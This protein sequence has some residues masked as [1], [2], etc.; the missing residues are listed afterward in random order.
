VISNFDVSEMSVFY[1]FGVEAA[2]GSSV[3]LDGMEISLKDLKLAI[4]DQKKLKN[5]TDFDLS[6]TNSQ[7][8]QVYKDESEMIN[9]GSTVSVGRIPMPRGEKK[10]WRQ[11]RVAKA[12]IP[13]LGN[14]DGLIPGLGGGLGVEG[15]QPSI[16]EEERL[17]Q[18]VDNS[19]NEYNVSN[20]ERI[21]NQRAPKP[22]AGESFK[23]VEK[24]N[25][26][27][28]K[29]MFLQAESV[30]EKLDA[31]GLKFLTQVEIDGYGKDK[32]ESH[33]WLKQ[34]DKREERVKEN[35]AISTKVKRA[36]DIGFRDQRSKSPK[37]RKIIEEKSPDNSLK[38][39]SD[40]EHELKSKKK[41]LTDQRN[42]IVNRSQDR[43]DLERAS[44][45][46]RDSLSSKEAI[47]TDRR[48]YD[49]ENEDSKRRG[50]GSPSKKIRDRSQEKDRNIRSRNDDSR[51]VEEM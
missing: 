27:I 40:R 35:E 48:N 31:N 24:K 3:L 26:G 5:E 46:D 42:K 22:L 32:K 50:S 10:I 12:D 36:I 43:H 23:I 28:P 4:V 1:T 41:A 25:T 44:V 14:T 29:S 39:L 45:K 2:G 15:Q 34:D 30:T 38:R 13:V 16:T 8:K 11:D 9:C 19:G 21:R 18:I 47:R 51:A 6:V 17:Q 33:E 7:T 49:I 20:W 37:E